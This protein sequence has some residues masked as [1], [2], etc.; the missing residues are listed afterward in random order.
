MLPS[1]SLLLDWMKILFGDCSEI[2]QST[3]SSY[4]INLANYREFALKTAEISVTLY[5]WYFMPPTLHK[6]LIHGVS[7]ISLKAMYEEKVKALEV[8]VNERETLVDVRVRQVLRKYLTDGQISLLL[9]GKKQVKSWTPEEMGMA[10]AI[11]YLSKRCYIYLRK[12]LNFP[13]PG[14]S[15]LQRWASSID[16]RQGLLKDVIHIMK[17]A[18]LNLKEFE[19]V[20]VILFDEM[21]VE[22]YFLYFAA[23]EVVGPHK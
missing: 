10:F 2:L 9:S 11:R 14:I 22:E 23:D 20:A 7:I 19:K 13:L 17:V 18:A 21:K 5:P 12:Q 1:Q 8:E 16:M 6:V 4:E 15:T 3:A